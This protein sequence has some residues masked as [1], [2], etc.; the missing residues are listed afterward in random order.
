M[1]TMDQELVFKALADSG[2]RKLLDALRH[3]DGQ[4]LVDLQRVLPGM[5]RFGVMKHLGQL[6]EAGMITTRKVGREK[7]HFLNPV[8]IQQAYDRWVSNYAQPFVRRMTELQRQLEHETNSSEEGIPM[9]KQTIS[10]VYHITIRTTPEKL[11][12]ALTDG[13]ATAQYYFNTRVS[14]DWREGGAYAY[15]TGP[16]GIGALSGAGQPMIEG[17]ILLCDPPRK[18]VQTFHPLW[19]EAGRAAPKSKVTFELE[20]IGPVTRLTLTHEALEADAL[21]TK[22]MIEGWALIFSGLKTLLETGT[23]L[24]P[25]AAQS[26]G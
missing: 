2:R 17:E 16:G 9:S 22:S 5:T 14:G 23:P 25:P 1:D 19:T 24:M 10:H 7:H 15:L 18:L 26:G 20:Q 13:D 6:E 11:W 4:T 21:L 8:P 12:H 3:E